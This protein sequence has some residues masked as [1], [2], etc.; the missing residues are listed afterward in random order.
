MNHILRNHPLSAP[1]QTHEVLSEIRRLSCTSAG[2][3]FAAKK[4]VKFSANYLV[5]RLRKNIEA[6]E[7]LP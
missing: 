7:F 1:L 5:K 4:K 3:G 2:F 6:G